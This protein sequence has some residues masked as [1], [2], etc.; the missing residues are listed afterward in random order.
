MRRAL[1]GAARALWPSHGYRPL[2]LRESKLVE[3]CFCLLKLVVETVAFL[4]ESID[5]LGPDSCVTEVIEYV[6]RIARYLQIL[7]LRSEGI[8]LLTDFF[9]RSVCKIKLLFKITLA[10]H[11]PNDDFVRFA[12]AHKPFTNCET[13]TSSDSANSFSVRNVMLCRPVSSR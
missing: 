3:F 9:N 6:T 7:K 13:F 5:S 11:C 8:K 1:S 4:H 10:C 2:R 12:L